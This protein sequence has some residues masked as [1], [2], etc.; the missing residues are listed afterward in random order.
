MS[1]LDERWRRVRRILAMRLDNLGDVIMTGPALRA[2]RESLPGVHLTLMVSHGARAAAQLLPWVD[3]TLPWRSI[4]QDLGDLPF[5]PAREFGLI[6]TLRARRFDAAIIFTSFAQSPHV[7]AYACYLAGIP[8]R[9]G[10]PKDFAGAVL[11]DRP[12]TATPQEAHRWSAT[13]LVRRRL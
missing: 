8:L 13:S 6:Q 9:L 12:A 2:I 7:A 3:E 1:S 4:W 5:D 10:E 11:S